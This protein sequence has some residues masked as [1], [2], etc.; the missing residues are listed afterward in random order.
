MTG[1]GNLECSKSLFCDLGFLPQH[2][3]FPFSYKWIPSPW[4]FSSLLF[5]ALRWPPVKAI[6]TPLS[7]YHQF[8]AISPEAENIESSSTF[9]IFGIMKF[10]IGPPAVT[11]LRPLEWKDRM[12]KM[13]KFHLTS[14]C[15]NFVETHSFRRVSDES[16]KLGEISA[17][18]AVL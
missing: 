2:R 6:L 17:F 15:G 12:C 3:F 1:V 5:W 10:W 4:L 18:Y 8:S 7:W 9:L 16:Q 11:Y 14:G 13:S